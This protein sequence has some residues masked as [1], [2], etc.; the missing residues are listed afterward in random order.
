M[1][2]GERITLQ[3]VDAGPGHPDLLRL[4]HTDCVEEDE[5]EDGDE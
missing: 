2:V 5:D 3:T 4:V 1:W